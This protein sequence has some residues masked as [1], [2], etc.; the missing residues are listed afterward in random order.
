MELGQKRR[1]RAIFLSDLHLGSIGCKTEPLWDFLQTV[2]ADEYYLVGDIVDTWIT[3]G[4]Q[5]WTEAHTRIFRHLIGL[6]QMG[7]DVYLMPGNHD[8][9]G[10]QLDG[11]TLGS[12][13]MAESF[14]HVT[15]DGRR[16]LVVHGD[17]FDPFTTNH[18]W[19]AYG[20][21]LLYEE[22]TVFNKRLNDLLGRNLDFASKFKRGI[23]RV[24]KRKTDYEGQLRRHAAAQ[25]LDG[26]I[27]G[28]IHTPAIRVQD[29]IVYM[30]PGDWVEHCTAL[31]EHHDGRFELLKWASV[32]NEQVEALLEPVQA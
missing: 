25:G 24:V 13:R 5:S 11:I 32:G 4:N 3:W 9:F 12:L 29:G 1:Y 7:T 14:V 27:C 26:V 23:K 8:D 6:A 19:L 16:L 31:A 18:R 20:L 28:H 30:N 17:K 22:I 15:A 21:A 10:A 2:H